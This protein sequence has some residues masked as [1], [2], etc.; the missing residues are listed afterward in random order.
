MSALSIW[1]RALSAA[2]AR[3]QVSS[4][5]ERSPEADICRQWY[6]TVLRSIQ[7]AAWWPACRAFSR[8]AVVAQAS[9]T[10]TDAQPE[11]G[12]QYAYAQPEG[13]LRPWHLTDFS[14]FSMSRLD[15]RTVLC[16]N[17]PQ[18]VLVYAREQDDVSQWSALQERA[19]YYALAASITPQLTG[20]SQ[21]I[22]MNF[23]LA[24]EALLEA[25]AAAHT[26]IGDEQKAA[27]PWLA[28]RSYA[29]PA[30]ARYFYPYGELFSYAQ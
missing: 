9:D 28:A 18:A 11:P 4:L 1:N 30:V 14:R 26:D 20:R 23:D 21:L 27:V 2:N 15:N 17:T 29:P 8:L 6:P 19:V 22:K 10:W 5:D 24:N 25:R 16:S 3:G 13:L 12:Y 7:S